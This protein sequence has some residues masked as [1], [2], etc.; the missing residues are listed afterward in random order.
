VGVR[1]GEGATDFNQLKAAVQKESANSL[2]RSARAPRLVLSALRS[3]NDKFS[4]RFCHRSSS[5]VLAFALRATADARRAWDTCA[6]T[7]RTPAPLCVPF[8]I[9]S[10]TAST[11]APVATKMDSGRLLCPRWQLLMTSRPGSESP[12][13]DTVFICSSLLMS[14]SVF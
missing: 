9:S 13:E 3:L 1:S 10:T 11:S 8:S 7:R 12:S 5:A 14:C 4:G 2:V 6:T